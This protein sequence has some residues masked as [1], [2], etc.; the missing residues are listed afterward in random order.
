MGELERLVPA[1]IFL[2]LFIAVYFI[3]GEFLY[4]AGA[5]DQ[6]SERDLTMTVSVN[7]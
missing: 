5:D 7:E 1:M 4:S 6:R 3:A 2:L